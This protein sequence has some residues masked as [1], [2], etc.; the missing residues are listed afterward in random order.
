MNKLTEIESSVA[1]LKEDDFA[2]FRQ[3][4]WEYENEKWDRQ[5]EKDIAGKKLDGLAA[6]AIADFKKGNFKSL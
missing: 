1:K 2:K 5:I 6:K 3:W 4:F